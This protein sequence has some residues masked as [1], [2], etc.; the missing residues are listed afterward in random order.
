MVWFISKILRPRWIKSARSEELGIR[1]LGV[2]I[3]YYKRKEPVI[4]AG[5][6]RY[7]DEKEFGITIHPVGR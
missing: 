5:P 3:Y 6:F 7:V 4:Y 1:I 2:N